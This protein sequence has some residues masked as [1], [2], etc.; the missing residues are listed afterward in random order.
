MP[1]ITLA[2]AGALMALGGVFF[3][4]VGMAIGVWVCQPS[5][6]KRRKHRRR[7]KRIKAVWRELKRDA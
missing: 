6:K 7:R 5:K 4:L 2:D 3:L 1:R